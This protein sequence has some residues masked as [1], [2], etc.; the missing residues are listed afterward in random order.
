MMHIAGST[1]LSEIVLSN[2][3]A[4]EPESLDENASASQLACAPDRRP[5]SL[6]VR[7]ASGIRM[8]RDIREQG[9]VVTQNNQF[10]IVGLNERQH[11]ALGELSEDVGA[12]VAGS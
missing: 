10:K 7:I 8:G 4:S 11:V 1:R 9:N 12:S 6:S 2:P 3:E 5:Q